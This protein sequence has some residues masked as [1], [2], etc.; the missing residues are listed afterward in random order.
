MSYSL[1]YYKR[2]IGINLG[3][4]YDEISIHDEKVNVISLN[5]G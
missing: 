4:V 1:Q 3:Y 5:Q 2:S